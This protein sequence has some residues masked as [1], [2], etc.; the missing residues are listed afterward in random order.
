VTHVAAAIAQVLSAKI[1]AQRPQ[2]T[3]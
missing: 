3:I 1:W 2:Q